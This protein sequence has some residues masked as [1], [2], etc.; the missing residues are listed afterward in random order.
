M[1]VNIIFWIH[2]EVKSN[3]SQWLPYT[4]FV[5]DTLNV[6]DKNSDSV[7]INSMVDSDVSVNISDKLV[8]IMHCWE[9]FYIL[10]NPYAAGG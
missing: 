9:G 1:G 4:S 5:K 8:I 6:Y 10:V 3:L 7:M 2:Y